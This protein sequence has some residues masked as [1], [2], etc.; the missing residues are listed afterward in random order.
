MCGQFINAGLKWWISLRQ[1]FCK[2]GHFFFGCGD[3]SQNVLLRSNTNVKTNLAKRSSTLSEENK[4]KETFC[5]SNEDLRNSSKSSQK[6]RANISSE[7]EVYRQ[8]PQKMAKWKLHRI[9]FFF[10]FLGYDA[11]KNVSV[12]KHNGEPYNHLSLFWQV[13]I[14][15]R[16]LRFE[17]GSFLADSH[18][19]NLS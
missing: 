7:V 12:L 17:F 4:C 15:P 11:S 5:T 3:W 2:S 16:S 1:L 9:Q 19:G 14:W 6:I 18:I 13:R 8:V 10:A